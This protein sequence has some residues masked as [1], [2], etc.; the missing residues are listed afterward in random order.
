[1][2]RYCS[3]KYNNKA[4]IKSTCVQTFLYKY[5]YIALQHLTRS[6]PK[7]LFAARLICLFIYLFK[8]SLTIAT[9]NLVNLKF[10]CTFKPDHK[11]VLY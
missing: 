9:T 1:M 7:P 4:P 5:S 10:H 3:Y 6:N 2:I 11:L 8:S